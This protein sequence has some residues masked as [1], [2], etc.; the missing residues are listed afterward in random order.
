M[1]DLWKDTRGV[2]AIEASII[3]PIFLILAG[4]GI[5]WGQGFA[6]RTSTAQM[7]G[8]A[9]NAGAAVLHKSGTPEDATAAARAIIDANVA[10]LLHRY[11]IIDSTDI[12]VSGDTIAVGMT[13]HEP[14][15]FPMF[16]DQVTSA[17][18]ATS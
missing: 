6:L 9:A 16:Q 11:T 15:L 7:V 1:R 17:A 13:M 12:T 14:A 18:T 10:G 8:A 5:T 2:V 4:Q 3:L